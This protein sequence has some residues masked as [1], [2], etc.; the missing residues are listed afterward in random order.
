MRIE[1]EYTVE[2]PRE[3]VYELLQ[4]PE[5][6]A[7]AMPGATSLIQLS[8]ESYDCRMAVKV[9]PVSGA[10]SG[11]VTVRDARWPEHFVLEVSGR[12][13]AGF[14]KGT[15]TVDLEEVPGGT[16]IRYAGETQVGGRIAQVGQRLIESVARKLINDGLQSLESDLHARQNPDA[17][18]DAQQTEQENGE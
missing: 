9:G 3:M 2:G 17:A 14:L 16:L 11:I 13:A 8:E 10:Y 4:D 1:G 5:A 18:G 7:R 6:L 12:G 15:G